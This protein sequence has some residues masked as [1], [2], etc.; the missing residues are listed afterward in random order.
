LLCL[1]LIG[2]GGK[3][4]VR[5]NTNEAELRERGVDDETVLLAGELVD[6]NNGT[7]A[8]DVLIDWFRD[9]AHQRHES[10]PEALFI[11]A[12]ALASQGRT[13]RAFYYLDELLDTYPGSTLWRPAVQRQYDLAD[14]VLDRERP[15]IGIG[16]GTSYFDALEMLFRIQQ[17]IPGSNVAKEALLRTAD[18]YFDN[19]DYD[20]AE[21]AYTVFLEGYPR[22]DEV[23]RVRRRQAWSN[24]LQY[25]GPKYDPTP[26]LDAQAQFQD[27]RDAG[28]A[29]GP[30]VE[31]ALAYIEQQFIEKAELQAAWY[32]RTRRPEAADRIL[33][34]SRARYEPAGFEE[35]QQPVRVP[36]VED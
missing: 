33:A 1:P 11:A 8:M 32:E 17:R 15:A 27:L 20:F 6:A 34:E 24:L 16:R 28:E 36:V 7:A 25:K 19:G 26:L 29:E 23:P 12:N 4:Y 22:S 18:F 3:V 9:P 31:R 21:D 13:S 2:C 14:A 30:A 10:R 35:A 5:S